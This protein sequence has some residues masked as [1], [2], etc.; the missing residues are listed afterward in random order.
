MAAVLCGET[1]SQDLGEL[2]EVLRN[3]RKTAKKRAKRAKR[4]NSS[5]KGSALQI[6]TSILTWCRN[7]N[8]VHSFSTCLVI[9]L[10][11][12]PESLELGYDQSAAA[13]SRRLNKKT[14]KALF[15][16]YSLS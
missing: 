9:S 13:G 4:A 5:S 7:I 2:G 16:C 8:V 14:N 15:H 11:P 3:E 10:A 1:R 12:Y 6:P